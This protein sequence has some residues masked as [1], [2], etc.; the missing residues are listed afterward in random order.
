[1]NRLQSA[2]NHLQALCI[3]KKIDLYR[4]L[5]ISFLLTLPAATPLLRTGFFPMH[6]YTHVAR[7]AELDRGLRGGSIPA[8][9]SENFGFGY[10][11][12]LLH[13]YSPLPYYGA[14]L[15][16][17]L[18]LS[19]VIAVKIIF[20]LNFPLGFI[21]M[22]LLSKEYF[23]KWGGILSA[24]AFT[25]APYRSVQ[26][27]VRG[28]LAEMMATTFLP[29]ALWC[30][31]HL[32]KS[33]KVN[34]IRYSLLWAI[35]S[36][37][38]IS[39][40]LLSH[41]VIAL[42]S[43]PLFIA[44][45]GMWFLYYAF[46]IDKEIARILIKKIWLIILPFIGSFGLS[47][48]FIMPALLEKKYTIVD[49]IGGGLSFYKLHFVYLKQ[50]VNAH[51]AYGGS[52]LGPQD[53]ISFQ[54]GMAQLGLMVTAFVLLL[55]LSINL[56]IKSKLLSRVKYKYLSTEQKL[57]LM[58]TILVLVISTFMMTRFST[59][60][61]E[62]IK[63]LQM[64]QFPWRFLCITII[65]NAFIGGSI[66][67]LLNSVHQRY[68]ILLTLIFGSALIL[69][70]VGFF[71][72]LRYE[73]ANEQYYGDPN[74][75]Q[76]ELSSVLFDY[77]PV[78]VKEKPPS[79]LEK[80]KLISGTGE[81]AVLVWDYGH[82]NIEV[83]TPTGTTLEIGTFYFPGW[84]TYLDSNIVD[85]LASNPNGFIQV[86]IPPGSH[87]VRVVLEKTSIQKLADTTT[88]VTIIFFVIVLSYL[89]IKKFRVGHI[90][91]DR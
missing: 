32:S 71:K 86:Q 47:A 70:N 78:W 72:P 53:Q 62:L 83:H 24:L 59:P 49:S 51:W 2:L 91:I 20:Y 8:R 38:S 18:G 81:V 30:L 10:G 85:L 63:I 14:E 39:A 19:S 4:V 1:M 57:A 50:F 9:W 3:K 13:F 35:G 26:F 77:Q 41:N 84:T 76:T 6:D 36:S 46:V 43:M 33:L 31:Y 54:F 15:F 7:V 64:A 27:Y 61:W 56:K 28:A 11:M 25:Y 82:R 22:Y 5:L 65:C 37:L 87:I 75:I 45:A 48:W 79:G 89:S 58:F 73:D 12:P 66:S 34:N 42:F 88:L 52:I 68:K 69:M 29:V 90:L 74:R 60:V 80:V 21:F 44:W 23:G 17:L 40:V 16:S 55:L 67:L